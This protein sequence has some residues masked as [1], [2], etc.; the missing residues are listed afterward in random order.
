MK[1]IITLSLLIP[2]VL[3]VAGLSISFKPFK[4]TFETPYSALGLLF[5]VIALTFW[6]YQAKL[7]GKEEGKKEVLEILT[8]LSKEAESK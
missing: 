8:K 6:N 3:Y 7:Q 2:A 4:L 1:T 5:F